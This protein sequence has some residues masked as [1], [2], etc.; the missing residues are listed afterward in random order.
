MNQ[1]FPIIRR[2]R[3]PLLPPDDAAPVVPSA[4]MELPPSATPVEIVASAPVEAAVE[5]KAKKDKRKHVA[6]QAHIGAA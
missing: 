2:A 1:L 5:P 4:V 3:R 6:A